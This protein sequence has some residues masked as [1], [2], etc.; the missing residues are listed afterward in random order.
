MRLAIVVGF[1]LIASGCRK[2]CPPPAQPSNDAPNTVF[3]T[4]TVSCGV[5]RY[6]ISVPGGVCQV[7]KDDQGNTTG[8]Q[9]TNPAGD[10]ATAECQSNGGDGS[11]GT[12]TGDGECHAEARVADDPGVDVTDSQDD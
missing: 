9:C 7:A 8:G 4:T 5:N 10:T 6:E 1:V 3:A 11:C 2:P 12:T